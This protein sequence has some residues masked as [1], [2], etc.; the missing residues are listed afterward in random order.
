MKGKYRTPEEVI[1]GVR[2]NIT[3]YTRLFNTP[4]GEVVLKDLEERFY[5]NDLLTVG[6]PHATAYN[7]GLRD[8]VRHIK[9]TIQDGEKLNLGEPIDG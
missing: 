3:V 6:D 9:E 1:E 8:A 4:D 7:V 5:N 2:K